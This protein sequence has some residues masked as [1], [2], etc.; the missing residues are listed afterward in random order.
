[1]MW[2]ACA[3]ALCALGGKIHMG[4]KAEKL[5]FDPAQGSW[6]LQTTTRKIQA[7]HILCSAAIRDVIEMLSN[8]VSSSAIEDARELS[9]R[10]F[11]T[12]ALIV[13]NATPLE[14]QWIYVH[15]SSV[16][17]GRIQNFGAWSS[18]MIPIPGQAC[19]GL[20]YF[21]FENDA[22][23]ASTD[24]EL[25]ELAKSELIQLGFAKAQDIVDGKVIRQAKA[26]PVYDEGY[27]ERIGRIREECET[28][29]P[30]LHMMGRNG[31]HRYNNQDHS[32]LTA[33]LAVENILA[34][35]RVHD[36]WSINL[37]DEYIESST[38]PGAASVS[39][40][41]EIPVRA[42]QHSVNGQS[43]T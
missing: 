13:R 37:S 2:E 19:F 42:S 34:G 6:L 32:M 36:V 17:V 43:I 4:E 38:K 22:L 40:L 16:K 39:G 3:K 18:Q 12:V 7:S 11:I 24:L 20:E 33:K 35:S 29:F 10:D 8:Q 21:C 1:M 41:R 5:T 23:W 14:D 28:R 9:Y 15:D 30:T 25:L 31:L 27:Q 26:Y